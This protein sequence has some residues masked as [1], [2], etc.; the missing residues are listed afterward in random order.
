MID[1]VQ[2]VN[3][4]LHFKKATETGLVSNRAFWNLVKP[5]LSNKGGL[6]RNDISLIKNDTIVTEDRELAEI[7]NDHYGNIVE[8]S[9]GIKP[10]NV[11]D[12]A[13]TDDDRQI[14]GLILEKYKN[15]PSILAIIQNPAINFHSFSFHEVEASQVRKQLKSLDGGKSTGEDQIPPKLALSAADE[16][17]LPL[18]NAI[19][20]SIRNYRLPNN[21]KRAAVCPLDKGDANRTVERSCRPI[22][23]TIIKFF[24][25]G[26]QK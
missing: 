6:A 20:S 19:N 12:A 7:F 16:L 23:I 18:T 10:C 9:S 8:R 15:H 2:P 17:A 24:K 13:A 25:V 14:I 3:I 4:Q 1:L 5:F 26:L 22:S 21:G 11:A